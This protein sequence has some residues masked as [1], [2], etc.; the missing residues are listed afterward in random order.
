MPDQP[1]LDP[2]ARLQ[3][4]I[5]ALEEKQ[6]TKEVDLSAEILSLRAVLASLNLTATT[7]NQ[8]GGISAEADRID[9]GGNAVG[10]DNI[11]SRHEIITANGGSVA[12][13]GSTVNA[14]IQI[15]SPAASALD[16]AAALQKYLTNI[17]EYSRH[18]QLQGIRSS[19]GLVSIEL[20]DIY[21]TL[22]I[23]NRRTII[24]EEQWIDEISHIAPGEEQRLGQVPIEQL[25]QAAQQAKVKVQE[26]LRDNTRLVVLGDPGCGKTTLLKYLALTFARDLKGEKNLVESRLQLYE[27]RLRVVLQAHDVAD[28]L[29][30]ED[31]AE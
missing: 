12:I 22:T 17:I 3:Q 19:S 16:D 31:Q 5:A 21:I 8:N 23:T 25:R 28:R 13:S 15:G 6:R 2:I 26:A 20:E 18:L 24:D 29:W 1:P 14:D 11:V 30:A 27:P 4:N 10:R 7:V 9:I